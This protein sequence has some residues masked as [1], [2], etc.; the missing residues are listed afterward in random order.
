MRIGLSVPVF[1]ADV[2]RPMAAAREAA[3]AGFDGVF[4]PD[5]VFPPGRPDR[6][7]VEATTLL[8]AC[9]TAAP[10]AGRG[11]PRHPGVPATRG[12]AGED[13]R[14]T[15]PRE[16]RPGDRRTR[17]GGRE[18]QGRTRG[19]RA[20]LPADRR[21][22]GG[23]RG[24]RAGAAD[25]V[26]G[27]AVAGRS[28]DR[29]RG[30]AA[31]AAR[32]GAGLGRRHQRP[33]ARRGG[34]GGGR[35]ERV[36]ARR[37]GVRRPRGALDPAHRRGRPRYRRR[38]VPTW[39]GIALVGEDADDLA[40]L[41]AG[42]AEKGLPMSIWRGTAWT[43]SERSATTSRAAGCAWMI[44]TAAGPPDRTAVIGAGLRRR[45]TSNELKRAKRAVRRRVLCPRATPCP[46]PSSRPRARP[47]PTDRLDAPRS[48]P[49]RTSCRSGR[50]ARRC[51]RRRSSPARGRR[52]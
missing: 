51:R 30:R 38:S 23:P 19:A 52:A 32:R 49:A 40:R 20:A 46:R 10:G 7:S 8:A 43:T 22:D 3:A 37:R 41:E 29:T 2:G 1:T 5:H 36:G 39:G 12:D 26:R 4:A 25:A 11:A 17:A 28:A 44:V 15:G 34:A 16:R 24:D 18:R 50:S 45:M 14:G 33:G 6:P 31:P 13:R 27:T 42:R 21:A 35:V 47:S 48:A 9:A